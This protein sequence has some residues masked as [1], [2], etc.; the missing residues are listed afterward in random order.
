MLVELG[1][2][3]VAPSFHG[4]SRAPAGPLRPGQHLH[5]DGEEDDG[6][7][8]GEEQVAHG[9]VLL[10]QE[11]AQGEGD[12]AAQAPV[13]DDELVLG[14]QL[15]DAELVDEPGQAQHTCPGGG[16]SEKQSGRLRPLGAPSL[17]E[18][19]I[20]KHSTHTPLGSLI[21]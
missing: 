2:E 1:L 19:S 17:G 13:G 20:G 11:V 5:K 14:R 15:H 10:V 9:K 16:R 7:D 6:D 8:G 21:S 3:P 18:A 4:Q 12:G